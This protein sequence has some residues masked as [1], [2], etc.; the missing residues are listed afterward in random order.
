[1]EKSNKQLQNSIKLP[2]LR[3]NIFDHFEIQPITDTIVED[4]EPE[5][6]KE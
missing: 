3:K 4:I 2:V 6:H 5:P 1:M